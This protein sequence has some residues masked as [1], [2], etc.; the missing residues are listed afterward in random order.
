[1]KN[2]RAVRRVTAFGTSA[3]VSQAS[4]IN[5]AAVDPRTIPGFRNWFVTTWAG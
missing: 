2:I 4:Y 1:M 3:A 5:G